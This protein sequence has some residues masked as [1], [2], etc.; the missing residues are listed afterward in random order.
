MEVGVV[1]PSQVVVIVIR[2]PFGNESVWATPLPDGFYRLENSLFLGSEISYQ[3]VVETV[4]SKDG[5]YRVVSRVRV[6]SGNRTLL[7]QVKE[8]LDSEKGKAVLR[9]IKE[10]GGTCERGH[11]EILSINVPPETSMER[12]CQ[13]LSDH[14]A[15]FEY[16]DPLEPAAQG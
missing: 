16:L 12:L 14:G 10:L 15:E 7:A 4:P 2:T 8:G 3:D 5:L 6:K 9:A 13:S 11:E 1:D